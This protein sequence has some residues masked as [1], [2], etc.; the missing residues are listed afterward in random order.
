MTTK[1]KRLR[2][3]LFLEG[4]EIPIVSC[5]TQSF[6]NAPI[7]AQI[8]IPPVPEATK[9]MP[10]TLVHV[11]FEDFH[12]E[13]NPLLTNTSLDDSAVRNSPEP[14][15]GDKRNSQ[16]QFLNAGD[17]TDD[18]DLL[19]DTSASDIAQDLKNNR[20]KLLFVGE[21]M[22][23]QYTKNPSSRSIV[24]QCSDLSNY[25]DY[26][27]QW[28]NTGLFGPGIK[29]IFSGGATNLFT[30]FLSSKSEQ[31]MRVLLTR[32]KQY[33]NLKGLLGG[34]V[35]MLEAIGGSYYYKDKIRGQNIFFTTAELRLHITQMIAAIEDDTTSTRLLR[36]SG[37]GGMFSRMLGGLG[38][39]VSIRKTINALTKVIFHETYAQTCPY[40]TPGTEG[41]I[42]GSKTV[43]IGDIPKAR[44]YALG[45]DELVQTI[46]NVKTNL[47]PDLNTNPELGLP[48]LVRG[49]R[50][51]FQTSLRKAT[52]RMRGFNREL[53]R[54]GEPYSYTRGKYAQAARDLIRATT[55]INRWN[56]AKTS[57]RVLDQIEERLDSAIESLIA[58]T[59]AE[60][61]TTPKNEKIP[62]R[63]NQ[64]IFRPDIWFSSPPRCNVLFPELYDTLMYQRQF[65]AEP[66][67]FMLKTND[68]FFGEDALFDK[69]YFAPTASP[70]VKNKRASLRSVLRNDLLDHEL[71][72]GILPVFEKMGEFNVFVSRAGAQRSG[73][74]KVG[75]AQRT[76]NFL[77]F[78]HRFSS[79]RMNVEGPFNPWVA[80]GFPGVIIDKY[81][82]EDALLKRREAANLPTTIDELRSLRGTHFLGNFTGITHQI[83]NA[84]SV[85]KTIVQCSYPRQVDES[86]E[87]LV[88]Q[89]SRTRTLKRREDSD[90]VRTT[91][92]ASISQP[93]VLSLGPSFG[94]IIKVDDVT[95]KYVRAR[96][97]SKELP[98]YGGDRRNATG[99]LNTRV[100]IGTPIVA[101]DYG[102]DVIAL[103]GDAR[104]TVTFR[105]YR[106]QEI[107]PRYRQE[108]VE[109]PAEEFI[110]PGWYGDIWHPSKIADAYQTFLGTGSITET[111]EISL[112]SGASAATQDEELAEAAAEQGQALSQEDPRAN[113]LTF[114][115][116]DRDASIE[117]A[118]DFLVILYSFVRQN[119]YDVDEFIRT[120]TWRPI[121]TML[122]MFGS[123]D[124]EL[125]Y[126]G[127]RVL[128][129]VEG[130]HSRAFGP[131]DDLFGL[132]TPEIQSITGVRRGTESAQR[133][134]TRLRK[135]EKVL[136]LRSAL[137]SNVG[138]LG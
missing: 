34:V 38:G 50:R 7:Q 77:Y 45:A 29:A 82:N 31:I 79:R 39:Q 134:D 127:H 69:W 83:N 104:R 110:R 15:L 97:G 101:G 84:Q 67:R 52:K 33:P 135:Q 73:L 80:A 96:G 40:Y 106:V 85:G 24:L 114:L 121:A 8:Q 13:G 6:P 2:L 138:I 95:D 120:Y 64:Q 78:K 103:A 72:T 18:A 56:S 58:I 112:P 81:M 27:Y 91:D 4:V 66:T 53:Y 41:T 26:A 113:A 10:R 123:A 43:P 59:Q 122:D 111:T 132:V 89:E 124:L 87:F 125:D 133:A 131:Y 32:S 11:F 70:G 128:R 118:V 92:V 47:R 117:Q 62:A 25:W 14:T 74:D 109:L 5:V 130:I 42:S 88:P 108:I 21:L 37:Y 99:D 30:D 136:E 16:Q 107:I 76:V 94:E 116:L 51:S 35:H 126:E 63:L 75:F 105:A 20:F 19:F 44:K 100:P 9:L 36:H 115:S 129:G 137:L 65:M 119:G 46:R 90:A 28:N 55:L 54:L 12:E 48:A 98:L 61:T 57:S 3:R 60:I 22:G 49:V 102:E 68:E 1:A 86:S 71:F 93:K 23:F 17:G